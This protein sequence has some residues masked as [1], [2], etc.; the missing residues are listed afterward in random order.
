MRGGGYSLGKWACPVQLRLLLLFFSFLPSFQV[1]G[2]REFTQPRSNPGVRACWKFKLTFSLPSSQR[3][4]FLYD[5]RK[6]PP[7]CQHMIIF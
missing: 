2:T 1:A 5:T 4:L 7:I 6:F 3:S